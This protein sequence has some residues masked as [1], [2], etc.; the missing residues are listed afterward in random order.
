MATLF[1]STTPQQAQKSAQ[2]SAEDGAGAESLGVDVDDAAE[3]ERELERKLVELQ[4]TS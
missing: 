2:K 4:V 3:R 1:H